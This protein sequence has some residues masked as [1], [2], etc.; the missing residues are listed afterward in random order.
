MVL[1]GKVNSDIV[2]RLNRHGQ[3]A[4]G[5]SG[6]DGTLFEVRPH[7]DA[8]RSRVRRRGRAGRGGRAPPHRRGLHPR[9]ASA[10]TDREGN[11]YNVNA[12][13]AAG[14][15]AAALARH[16]A[17]FLTDI[18]GWLATRTTPTRLSR[19]PR[20]GEVENALERR[21]RWHAPQ[22][23]AR[24]W[25]RSAAAWPRPTSSTARCPHS[26]LLELFTDAGIG[27]KIDAVTSPDLAAARGALRDAHVRELAGGVRAR[28]GGAALGRRGPRVPGLLRRALGPQR[29][30]LPPEDHRR[31]HR[32]DGA[33]GGVSNLYYTAPAMRLAERLVESS[34]GGKVFLCNSGL[35]ANEC[36]MKL[37]RKRAHRRGIDEPEIVVLDRR[38]STAGRSPRSPPRRA[39]RARSSSGHCPPASWRCRPTIPTRSG[40][41]SA[42]GPR[43]SCWSRSR[44]RR[45][46]SRSP[47]R[48]S[49]PPVRRATTPAPS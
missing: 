22:A 37:A 47:T 35:E 29:R 28:G 15:V 2:S 4:V 1:L 13:T 19:R 48:C 20:S 14:K 18:A 7:P 5:L 34:L 9:V 43:P 49:S 10:G 24:A 39:W 11:S 40:L 33:L 27:T 36:A 16:K 30:P 6:E 12:D 46:C 23:R 26:L 25:R 41:P 45:A 3:P 44:A 31:D 8:E 38:A 17:I 42:R 21:L 32:A